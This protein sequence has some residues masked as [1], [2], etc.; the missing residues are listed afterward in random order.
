MITTAGDPATSEINGTE[1]VLEKASVGSG[2]AKR[3]PLN[4]LPPFVWN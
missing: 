1:G 4:R 3:R 2:Y